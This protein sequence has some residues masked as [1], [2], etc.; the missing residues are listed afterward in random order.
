MGP[1]KLSL[2]QGRYG[3]PN[4][5]PLFRIGW[6]V[7]LAALVSQGG[8]VFP[9]Q[10]DLPVALH[11]VEH[12]TLLANTGARGRTR[13]IQ[14]VVDDPRTPYLREGFLLLHET[15]FGTYL[16]AGRFVPAYG[17]RLDD[18]TSAIRRQFE[19]DS[20]LPESRVSGVELGIAPN[21]PYLNVSW[22]RSQARD[23]PPAA[24]DILDADQGNG[25]AINAGFRELGF[26]IG[27]SFMNRTR[28]PD[29]GGDA[30]V[31]GL[32]AAFNPWFYS[33]GLPFTYQ[34]EIDRGRRES[35]G[36]RRSTGYALYHELDWQAANGL[37]VLVKHDWE[38]PDREVRND[39]SHRLE[40]GA[41]LTP[42]PGITLDSR[43]RAL[44][45]AGGEGGADLFLQLHFWN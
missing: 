34:V 4:A 30:V 16:K 15:P 42:I 5:D 37:N 19:L 3:G 20:S 21:Y 41:Q 23:V 12:V 18:H 17:L 22:F 11:P 43:I 38:D 2:L 29:N 1:S 25:T 9:M 40:L 10:V 28:S 6:D 39:A 26:S 45:P 14:E 31:Y 13:G 24:F 32:Q 35:P 27:A 33:R 36:G 7:R 8:V 44:L